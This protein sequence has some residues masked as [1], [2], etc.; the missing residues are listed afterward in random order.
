[1]SS[2][3][4][5]ICVSRLDKHY[6]VYAE[7]R[8]R[9]RQLVESALRRLAGLKPRH[10]FREFHA[11]TDVSFSIAK[12]ESVG[13]IGRNGS[14]KSTLLQ[15][16]CGT[17][18]PGSGSIETHG[19]IA[20]LLELGAGFHPEFSG[21]ENIHLYAALLGLGKAEI[22]ARFDSIVAFAGVEAFVDQPLKTYSSGMAMRIAFAVIAHVD[23]D[24]LVIDEAL[25][26]GDAR[27][28][29]KC[30]R[31]LREFSRTGTLLFVSH[32]CGAVKSLCSRVLWLENGR[33]L[34]DGQPKEVFDAYLQASYERPDSGIATVKA[35][36]SRRTRPVAA[37]RHHGRSVAS[38][39]PNEL[40]VSGFAADTA[41]FG[42]GRA[43]ITGVRF[44]DGDGVEL[45]R[46]AGGETVT[47]V[48][49]AVA[50]EFIAA[51]IVGFLVRDRLGQT[52][53]G[54]NACASQGAL[55]DACEAGDKLIAR[56]VFC[57]PCLP[58]GSYAVTAGVANG[59]QQTHTI[60]CWMH[61]ALVFE[62]GEPLPAGG[63]VGLPMQTVS[64]ERMP[65][66]A[67]ARHQAAGRGN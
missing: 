32:D 46:L 6:K 4:V 38:H 34:R 26:V 58:P 28:T 2:D 33:L 31:F 44:T 19:R 13:I 27:F 37:G 14:G 52:L 60:E 30:M 63:L 12:G 62:G 45:S 17:L 49:E 61:D 21:R 22:V 11:L 51:P 64:L 39:P 25:A 20:A 47:L 35:I 54:E 66:P 36:D 40:T 42:D 5:A 8:D 16:I 57:M 3:P 67:G 55:D 1:M 65:A 29:Q 56:F 48:V 41:S 18:S 24:I 23:A 9:L 50:D 59:S 53:F 7:P 15:I 10:C 43:R